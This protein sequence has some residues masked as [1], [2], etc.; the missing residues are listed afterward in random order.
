MTCGVLTYLSL[1]ISLAFVIWRSP[2]GERIEIYMRDE[3]SYDHQP[4]LR[5]RAIILGLLYR[6]TEENIKTLNWRSILLCF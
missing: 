6:L 5:E 4:I 3:K 2:L 1:R